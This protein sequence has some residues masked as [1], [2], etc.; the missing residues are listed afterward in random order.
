MRV[1][2]VD[3]SSMGVGVHEASGN[4]YIVSVYIVNTE[5]GKD[6]YS[7]YQKVIAWAT[8]PISEQLKEEGITEWVTFPILFPSDED[9]LSHEDALERRKVI[10]NI[11]D[12]VRESFLYD[13]QNGIALRTD[14]LE[15]DFREGKMDLS[16]AISQIRERWEN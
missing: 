2:K 1:E 12:F 4:D 6:V 5:D 7:T 15:T 9:L 13:F 11:G 16:E 14:S 8:R 3:L 10:S